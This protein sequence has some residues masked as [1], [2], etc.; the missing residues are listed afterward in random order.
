MKKSIKLWSIVAFSILPIA[1]VSISCNWF[2]KKTKKYNEQ[3][4]AVNSITEDE[5]AKSK[6]IIDVVNKA[7]INLFY[8]T[9]GV[10]TFYNMV[11]LAMLAKT[12]VHFVKNSALPF[13]NKMDEEYFLNFLTN[14]KKYEISPEKQ[15]QIDNIK[16]QLDK[17]NNQKD[18][19]EEIKTKINVLTK[20]YNQLLN[21]YSNSSIIK[22]SKFGDMDERVYDA[23]EKIIKNNL[24]KKINLWVNSDHF[25]NHPSFLNLLGYKN[26]FI[27]GLEDAEFM[28][29]YYFEDY[30]KEFLKNYNKDTKKINISPNSYSKT[31]QYIVSTQFEKVALWW[32]DEEYIPKWYEMGAKRVYLYDNETRTKNVIKNAIFSEKNKNNQRLTNFWPKII[33]MDWKTER[34]IVNKVQKNGKPSLFFLGDTRIKLE[35]EMLGYI[36]NTYQDKYNIYY[37]GHPGYN[38]N[39]SWIRNTI[40]EHK[41]IYYTDPI[42]NEKKVTKLKDNNSLTVLESQIS[43]EE[44]TTYHATQEDGLRFDKFASSGFYSNSL[45][46]IENGYNTIDD[47]IFTHYEDNKNK[48]NEWCIEDKN[49]NYIIDY[50]ETKLMRKFQDNITIKIKEQS[51]NKQ[52]FDINDFDITVLNKN[53][54]EALKFRS[55]SLI[56]LDYDKDTNSLKFKI[57]GKYNSIQEFSK[58]II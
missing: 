49:F 4:N 23:F 34:D 19:S 3:F 26:V 51:K 46:G 53:L 43:S 12:E 24:D 31:N 57:K 18:Q 13:Q 58:K 37:K 35:K 50:W 30:K 47:F 20:Q 10:Q 6:N 27:H 17:L 40:N 44:L 29:S 54:D 28:N 48:I 41:N 36:V 21:P 15:K 5:I 16:E 42:T 7:D 25:S 8:T 32:T 33:G 52:E 38:E 45:F 9:Y 11:R 14:E 56:S 39:E 2:S 22:T 55:Y 1:A